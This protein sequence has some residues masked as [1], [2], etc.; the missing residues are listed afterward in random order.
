MGRTVELEQDSGGVGQRRRRKVTEAGERGQHQ[1]QLKSCGG[2]YDGILVARARSG[3]SRDGRGTKVC[4]SGSGSGDDG[5]WTSSLAFREK[6][7]KREETP[8]FYQMM[9]RVCGGLP[10][11]LIEPKMGRE[12]KGLT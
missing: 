3:S 11:P 6:P 4:S 9:A 10:S 2:G 1:W 5:C 8:F 12:G 7:L